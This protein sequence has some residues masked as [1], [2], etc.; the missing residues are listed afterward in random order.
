MAFGLAAAFVSPTWGG[1]PAVAWAR[2][3]GEAAARS[4]M[5][6]AAPRASSAS[7]RVASMSHRPRPCL[8][9][10]YSFGQSRRPLPSRCVRTGSWEVR[11][12]MRRRFGSDT[13]PCHRCA[14]R[15]PTRTTHRLRYSQ[16]IDLHAGRECLWQ[17]VGFLG[18]FSCRPRQPPPIPTWR[19]NGNW[20]IWSARIAAPA[21]E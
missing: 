20:C 18:F 3:R 19:A 21:M 17:K 7:W 10:G 1:A 4:A 12:A 9:I 14:C 16:R 13:P 11:T 2:C 5:S 8:S 15:R 6:P